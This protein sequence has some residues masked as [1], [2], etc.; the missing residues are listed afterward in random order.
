LKTGIKFLDFCYY[1]LFVIV[2]ACDNVP[3]ADGVRVT[4]LSHYIIDNGWTVPGVFLPVWI[5]E[6]HIPGQGGAGFGSLERLSDAAIPIGGD[7]LGQVF[8][9][10]FSTAHTLLD[11][12]NAVFCVAVFMPFFTTYYF[13][14]SAMTFECPHPCFATN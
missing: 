7:V 9:T 6:I 11:D 10:D 4:H 12:E 8:F 5:G 14:F 3:A 13:C 1:I 2:T